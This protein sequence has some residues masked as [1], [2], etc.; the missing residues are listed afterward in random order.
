MN[1]SGQEEQTWVACLT[2]PG[3]AAIAT[4]A[5][6]GPRAWETVRTLFQPRS[7]KPLPATPDSAKLR[8]R[9]WL[10]RLGRELADEVVLSVLTPSDLE[11]HCH[12]GREVVR[13]LLDLLLQSGLHECGWPELLARREGDPLHAQAAAALSRATTVS[14]ASILLDQLSGAFRTAVSAVLA[15]LE[16]E[17]TSRVSAILEELAGRVSLGRH[18]TTPWRVVVAGAPNVGKS[19]L[20]NALAGY[21]RSVVSPTPGTTRDVVTVRLAIGWPVELVDTAGLREQTEALEGQG[22]E[23]ARR[24]AAGA[25]LCLWVVDAS[26]TPV[27]PDDSAGGGVAAAKT[28]LVLNKTDLAPAWD[29]EQA[30]GA[31][32]VSA[33][34]GSGLGEL[35]T[36]LERWLVPEPPPPGSAVPFTP[37]LCDAIEETRQLVAVG[38]TEK[39]RQRLQGVINDRSSAGTS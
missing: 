25:D 26:T 39:A 7:R 36:A 11:L 28:F 16:Q 15:G 3:R 12:G 13:L 17:D 20:V 1:N 8:G 24:E 10:G 37:E 38:Q 2:P 4:L 32:R 33:Q 14:T 19:S 21:Q 30:T 34:T 35:C 31:I 23:L 27:W 18:L 5:L 6:H 22:I 9:T 29:L